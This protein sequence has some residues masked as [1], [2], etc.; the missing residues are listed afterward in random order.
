M[1]TYFQTLEKI[2]TLDPSVIIPSHGMP[3]RSTFRL[4]ATLQ[5][6]YERE[7]T[8]QKLHAGGKTQTEILDIIYRGVNQQNIESHLTKLRQESQI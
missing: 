4:Q 6:R 7:K 3:M 1:A 8:I 2:I 5:H